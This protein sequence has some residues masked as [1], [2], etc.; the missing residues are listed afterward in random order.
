[1]KYNEV[2]TV[3]NTGGFA[4]DIP[5]SNALNVACGTTIRTGSKHEALWKG[6]ARMRRLTNKEFDNIVY[7]NNRDLE[8]L[9]TDWFNWGKLSVCLSNFTSAASSESFYTLFKVQLKKHK[10]VG[11]GISF[12]TRT[13]NIHW[14]STNNNRLNWKNMTLRID[15]RT[16]VEETYN[17]LESWAKGQLEAIEVGI[18]YAEWK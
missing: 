9:T 8:R 7:A 4:A 14:C 10:S 17:S 5:V 13:L 12:G 3:R 18:D 1:M 2:T 6:N 11:I 16:P 15:S